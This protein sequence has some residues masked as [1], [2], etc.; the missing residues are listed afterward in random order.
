MGAGWPADP[1][2]FASSVSQW[3]IIQAIVAWIHIDV[4]QMRNIVLCCFLK[5][6]SCRAESSGEGGAKSIHVGFLSLERKLQELPLEE[7]EE[8]EADDDVCMLVSLG[9]WCCM[10]VS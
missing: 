3:I 8:E 5:F 1:L 4:A 6:N 9:N 10:L 7:E 2:L